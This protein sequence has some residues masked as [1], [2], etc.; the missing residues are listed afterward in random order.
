M[1]DAEDIAELRHLIEKH[2]RY[3]HSSVARRVL[4]HWNEYLPRF[5]KVMPIDYKR[6]LEEQARQQR[7]TAP[8]LQGELVEVVNG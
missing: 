2:A 8:E 1:V 5:V 7:E 6:V 4:D 3:T